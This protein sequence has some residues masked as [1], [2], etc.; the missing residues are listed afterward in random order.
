MKI[1]KLF[2][3][4]L[5][6]PLIFLAFP[7]LSAASEVTVIGQNNSAVDP[8]NVQAAI[9]FSDPGDTVTLQRTF[10]FGIDGFITITQEGLIIRGQIHSSGNR[11]TNSP[12]FWLTTVT[13]GDTPFRTVNVGVTIQ[14]LYFKD[15]RRCVIFPNGSTGGDIVLRNNRVE[16]VIPTLA[17]ASLAP[18]IRNFFG[19]F[20]AYIYTAVNPLANSLARSSSQSN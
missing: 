9:D 10:D 8:T 15:T 2:A 17:A 14:D 20:A 7:Q 16:N 19:Y 1:Q 13:G 18:A 4:C 3:I 6:A 12:A 5:F 11:E